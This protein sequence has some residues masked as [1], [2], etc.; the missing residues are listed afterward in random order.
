MTETPPPPRSYAVT[1]FDRLATPKGNATAGAIERFASFADLAHWFAGAPS[2]T[3][4]AKDGECVIL[5]ATATEW[6]RGPRAAP[7]AID[8]LGLDVDLFHGEWR[9]LLDW[10]REAWP[11]AAPAAFIHTTFSHGLPAKW[12]P[13]QTRARILIPLARPV[14][15]A[16][17]RAL[18]SYVLSYLD[19]PRL[20]L[21]H[22]ASTDPERLWLTPRSGTDGHEEPPRFATIAGA[23]LDPDAPSWRV[24]ERVELAKRVERDRQA[25]A[26]GR[27]AQLRAAPHL[28]PEDTGLAVD[29]DL[30]SIMDAAG[31][32]HRERSEACGVPVARGT[33]STPTARTSRARTLGSGTMGATTGGATTTHAST[34]RRETWW[35]SWALTATR[36][37]ASS[38]AG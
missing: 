29:A 36:P 35:P 20:E 4:P 18:A 21:D 3:A 15:P 8:V 32:L 37:R 13:G 2:R 28:A 6:S 24:T 7:E 33:T 19:D 9:D 11:G 16:E 17:L 26:E 34:D 30:V 23:E 12:A 10:Y 27:A 22:G 5:G 31:Y 14:S 1:V 25:R 38:C